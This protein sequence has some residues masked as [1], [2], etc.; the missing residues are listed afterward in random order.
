MLSAPDSIAWLLNVR[1]ADVANSPLPHS[2]AI[3]HGGGDVDWFVDRRK[4]L[5]E[6]P[7]H[8]GNAVHVRAP[9]TMAGMLDALASAG[10]AVL[11]DEAATPVWMV[12]RLTDGGAEVIRGTDP[13]A[14]PKAC[15]NAVELDG[16][17]AAHRRDGA[18]LTRSWPGS[19]PRR[20][21][22]SANWTRSTGWRQGAP[23]ASTTAAQ[24]STRSRA[25]APT[26]PSSTTG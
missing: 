19:P 26:A 23:A 8:L 11:I 6:I 9:E 24:A 21:A 14:L 22:R 7:A 3:L 16:I 18:A 13:C 17:R 4:L 10:K 25:P 5:P 1:G 2:F 12:D 15:K 20:P